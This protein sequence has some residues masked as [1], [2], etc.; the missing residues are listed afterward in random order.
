MSHKSKILKLL[1][2]GSMTQ[3]ELAFSIYGDKNHGPNIY[4]AL[5]SLVNEGYV[6]RTGRNPSYYNL[7]GL[8]ISLPIKAKRTKKDNKIMDVKITNALIEK[9][10]RQVMLTDNYG[11]ED[12]LITDAFRKFP[13]NVDLEIVALKIG[14]IDITNSTNISRYK[15][16]ISVVELAECIVKI[17][18]IDE[19]IKDGDPEVVNEIARSNGKINLFSFASKYCCYHNKNVYGKD[20][21]SIYD[22]VLKESLPK[23]FDDIT[24]GKLDSWRKTYKYKKYNNYIT[25]KLDELE[26]KIDYRKRKFDHF[27]WFNNR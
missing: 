20:D 5:M 8:E 2:K 18:N 24:K 17:K 4:Y 19:R 26:I 3:G 7:S 13:Q 21:Y 22:T 9:A 10:H 1:E 6:A 12:A 23:Y 16:K 14:L 15:S 27:I 11:K 25:K